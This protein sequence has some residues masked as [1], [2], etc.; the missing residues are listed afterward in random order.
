MASAPAAGS[1]TA[2]AEAS[3]RALDQALGRAPAADLAAAPTGSAVAFPRLYPSTSRNRN[4][5]KKLV[6]RNGKAVGIKVTKSL[7]LGLDEKAIEAVQKWRFKP[8]TKDGKPVPVIASVE[9]NFRLL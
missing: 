1:E 8:G 3:D 5:R 9:V 6:R 7:G 2:K 4:I